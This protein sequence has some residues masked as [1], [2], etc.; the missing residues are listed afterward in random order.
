MGIPCNLIE[1][2]PGP[3]SNVRFHRLDSNPV[4]MSSAGIS[5]QFTCHTSL[6][7]TKFVFQ[8][9]DTLPWSSTSLGPRGEAGAVTPGSCSPHYRGGGSLAHVGRTPHPTF[10]NSLWLLKWVTCLNMITIAESY[11][12]THRQ[13][14]VWAESKKKDWMVQ[15][16]KQL[17]VESFSYA[18]VSWSYHWK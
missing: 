6:W 12:L 17:Q 10:W 8:N 15:Q 18:E 13:F 4:L 1:V 16:L 9:L 5:E 11:L 2:L 3:T 7:S 14:R